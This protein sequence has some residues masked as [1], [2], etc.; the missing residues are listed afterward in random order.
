MKV[1]GIGLSKGGTG[2]T[3]ISTT[4]ANELR[5]FGKVLLVD[6][7]PQGNAS[8]VFLKKFEKEL[9]DVLFEKCEINEAIEESGLENLYILPTNPVSTQ[10]HDYKVSSKVNDDWFFFSEKMELLKNFFDYV[11]IDTCPDFSALEKNFFM[12]CD[13]FIPVV[14]AGTFAVDGLSIF[15]LHLQQFQ[16]QR[17]K[18]DLIQKTLVVNNIN[19]SLSI[20]KM[21][22]AQ[23][24]EI[25]TFQNVVFIPQDQDFKLSQF[26]QRP[27]TN[28][29]EATRIA[30]EKLAEVTK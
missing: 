3:T 12:A 16:K 13:E 10:L 17:H 26:E 7:D 1:I 28:I 2:K 21:L 20:D 23:F 24:S 18:T 25:E 14:N 30:I 8:C 19:N 27:A 4:L 22:K 15:T 5:K 11:I 6:G 9:A 29:K